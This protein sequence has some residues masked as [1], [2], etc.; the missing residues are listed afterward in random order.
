[1]S[2]WLHTILTMMAAAHRGDKALA[3]SPERTLGAQG[4]QG[5]CRPFTAGGGSSPPPSSSRPGAGDRHRAG[6]SHGW[7][8][9]HLAPLEVGA[10]HCTWTSAGQVESRRSGCATPT[11]REGAGWAAKVPRHR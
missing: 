7:C 11:R 4:D 9:P 8:R 10:G 3:W 2:C 5:R 1:M 6:R